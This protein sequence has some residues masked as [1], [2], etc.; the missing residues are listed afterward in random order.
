MR[1]KAKGSGSTAK[2]KGVEGVEEQVSECQ[3]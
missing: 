2:E 3:K 1:R